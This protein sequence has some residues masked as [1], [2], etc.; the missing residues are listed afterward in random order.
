MGQLSNFI[1]KNSPTSGIL[2]KTGF[3]GIGA[4]KRTLHIPEQ[5]TFQEIFGN[6]PAVYHHKGPL[7]P[8]TVLVNCLRHQFFSRAALTENKYI[9]RRTRHLFYKAVNLQHFTALPYHISKGIG[10]FYSLNKEG[11]VLFYA[12]LAECIF[13]CRLEILNIEIFFEVIMGS[14]LHRLYG[15]LSRCI[16]GY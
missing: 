5:F 3:I 10:F 7:L 16:R 4:G 1:E 6:S 15:C 14:F 11:V 13:N 12:L 8:F 2:E 9:G